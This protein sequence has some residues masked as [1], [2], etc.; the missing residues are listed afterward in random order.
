[1]GTPPPLLTIATMWGHYW[2]QL[3]NRKLTPPFRG[4]DP[5][6]LVD[7]STPHL[8]KNSASESKSGSGSHRPDPRKAAFK[9]QAMFAACRSV[10]LLRMRTWYCRM[11]DHGVV[12]LLLFF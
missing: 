3:T 5:T 9:Q 6:S 4:G 7:A 10:E 1:M 2:L 11:V 12:S 8:F